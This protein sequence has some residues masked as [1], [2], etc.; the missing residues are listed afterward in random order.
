MKV[1]DLV[2]R[3][4]NVPGW[5]EARA[6]RDRMGHGIVLTKQMSGIPEHRCISVYYPK[7]GQ[8]YDIAESLMKVINEG[9]R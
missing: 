8:I 4:V 2:L 6:Q 9:G 1:G 3:K 5:K 7:T